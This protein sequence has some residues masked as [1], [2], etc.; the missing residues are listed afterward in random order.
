MGNLLYPSSPFPLSDIFNGLNFVNS[1]TGLG[2]GGN[3]ILLD[4]TSS[5]TNTDISNGY[6]GFVIYDEIFDTIEYTNQNGDTYNLNRGFAALGK[7]YNS[8]FPNQYWAT[9][10]YEYP[11]LIA[12][13]GTNITPF[14]QLPRRTIIYPDP[15]AIPTPSAILLGT[16][17]MGLTG[18]IRKRR[19][20]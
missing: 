17:G 7:N 11:T 5:I 6:K 14:H 8:G 18:W 4:V 20:L 19:R 12:T 13:V 3:H 9:S 16:I 2:I 10:Y 15:T 1:F